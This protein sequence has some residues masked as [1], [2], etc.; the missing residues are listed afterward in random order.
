[1]AHLRDASLVSTDSGGAVLRFRMLETV[2][3]LAAERVGVDDR[4]RLVARHAEYFRSLAARAE[5]ELAGPDQTAWMDQLDADLGNLRAALTW[6][7]QAHPQWALKMA[8]DLGHFWEVRGHLLEG[9]DWLE[10]ALAGAPRAP[11][12][13]RTRAVLLTG[14]FAHILGQP[15]L[16]W[17]R[18]QEGLALSRRAGDLEATGM[19]L[20]ALA[21]MAAKAGKLGESE[22]LFGQSAEVASQRNDPEAQARAYNGLAG[23]IYERGDFAEARQHSL[24]ALAIRRRH[25]SPRGTALTLQFL[26]ETEMMLGNWAKGQSLCEESVDMLRGMGDERSVSSALAA[27]GEVALGQG[28]TDL[29]RRWLEQALDAARQAGGPV[30][31]V[32]ALGPLGDTALAQGDFA[33]A[34]ARFEQCADIHRKLHD[35]HSLALSLA[36]LGTVAEREGEPEE[37]V[38]QLAAAEHLLEAASGA[39]GDRDGIRERLATLR[40]GMEGAVFE[41]ARREGRAVAEDEPAA[42]R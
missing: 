28:Q 11:L 29:A 25:G 31:I 17:E 34:R 8:A 10:R 5:P 15:G 2:R 4:R 7:L 33:T 40:A 39:T 27:L 1:L 35:V 26:G 20:Y 30:D 12:A 42:S 41:R 22:R 21:W 13:V 19:A 23:V 16:A 38:L 24:R 32:R 3:E 36:R 6:S 9:R 18:T 37:A 14:W